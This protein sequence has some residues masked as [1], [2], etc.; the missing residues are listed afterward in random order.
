MVGV[1]EE[2]S[3]AILENCCASASCDVEIIFLVRNPALNWIVSGIE[4]SIVSRNSEE[5]TVG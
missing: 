3:S 2:D 5:N 4:L 1:E